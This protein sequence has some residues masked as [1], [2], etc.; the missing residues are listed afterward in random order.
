MLVQISAINFNKVKCLKLKIFKSYLSAGDLY[1]PAHIFYLNP[2]LRAHSLNMP[3][4]FLAFILQDL[5]ADGRK[6]TTELASN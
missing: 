3:T 1:L 2:A 6:K 5:D 4:K